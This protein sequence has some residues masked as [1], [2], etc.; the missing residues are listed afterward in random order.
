MYLTQGIHRGVQR[1]PD[2]I[3]VTDASGSLSYRELQGRV[4]RLAGAFDKLGVQAGDRVAMLAHNSSRYVEYFL[5]A[6]WAGVVANPVNTRWSSAEIAYSLNDCECA[7]LIVDDAFLPQVAA[8]R[9]ACPGLKT[10]IHAGSAATPDGVLGYEDVLAAADPVEDRRCAGHDLAAILYTGGTTGFPKGVMLSH[11]N[12]WCSSVARMAEIP[13]YC[14]SVSLVVT[15]LFHVAGLGRLVNAMI[16]GGTCVM[17]P[18]FKPAAVLQAIAA[19]HVTD[20]VLVPSMIQMLLDDPAFDPGQIASLQRIVYGAAPISASLLD[21]VLDLMPWVEFIH[22]YGMTETA[23]SVSVNPGSNHGAEGRA[24]GRVRS[25]GRGGFGVEVKIIDGDGAEVARGTVG[26]IVVR[27]PAVMCGYWNK[28]EETR[29]ALRDGWLHT[30]DGAWMDD[31]GYLYVVERLKDM[32]ISGGENV[33]SAEVENALIRHPAVGACA[34][35]GVPHTTWGEAVHAVVVP[36]AGMSV[37]ADELR[38]HCRSLLAGYKCPKTVEVRDAL[39][40]SAAG[41]VLKNALRRPFWE[42]Q[43][44][45]EV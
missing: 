23:A 31:E 15:P 16:V 8:I 25:A 21:R 28:P 29:A 36:R 27:G 26:E 4:A 44:Q 39:P 43:V 40:M 12:F 17:Q 37:D 33:Y 24:N 34:V 6:W 18:H 38:E 45:A 42:V 32:I 41:K 3:A 30:G 1:H 9:A 10:V 20:V 2:K 19:H 14:D 22:T 11:A 13:N 5:S 35:I 7:L